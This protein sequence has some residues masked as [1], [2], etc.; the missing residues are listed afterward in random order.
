MRV[1]F[2]YLKEKFSNPDPILE[3]I[4]TEVIDTGDFT[5]GKPVEEFEKS[6]AKLIGAKH[7]IGV[8][9]GTDAIRLSLRALGVGPG[10]EVITAANTFV[11]SLGAIDELFAKPVLV[12]MAP[13]YTL[14]ASKIEKAITKK[15]KA[16]LPV[17]FTGEPAEMD[18]VMHIAKKHSLPVVEDACQAVL[19]KF[20][21]KCCGTI[22]NA[23]A[24]S[25][26]PLK[27]L[28]VFGDGGMIT[29]NDDDLNA[30]LRLM[31]NHGMKNR[32][33]ISMFGCNSRL[34]SVQAVVGNYL[35]KETKQTTQQRRLNAAYYD[36]KLEEIPGVKL[37]PRRPYVQQ[38]WHLYF[39]EVDASIRGRL[40][41]YLIESGI[42]AK[43]HYPIPLYL[44]EGLK[45]L[46]HKR[47]DFPVADRQCDRIITLRVDDH[48]TKN[49]QDYIIEKVK[50][51]T[52]QLA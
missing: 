5:L 46:G 7:A 31:R 23:G 36:M 22:G 28:N 3:K 13:W 4:K 44:Q 48:I 16:I 14:D 49:Q 32:D 39:F 11:A 38:C 33:E 10:D 2:S 26:H 21:D 6:F 18:E 50:E 34:D 47:G 19:A 42:E 27:N 40:Y 51:F 8:A 41:H 29:T 35:I 9:N 24:F 25:L 37:A 15:T 43:I 52:C 1:P 45:H 20:Q 17:H 12:D 30:K